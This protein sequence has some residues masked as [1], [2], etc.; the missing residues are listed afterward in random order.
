MLLA[1]CSFAW[2][3]APARPASRRTTPVS[4]K[5]PVEILVTGVNS[6]RISSKIVIQNNMDAVWRTLT[7]YD[8]LSTHVP[9]LIKSY[10]V[11]QKDGAIRVFQ[12]GAQNVVGFDFSA[13]LLMVM[14]EVRRDALRRPLP[15][16]YLS[17]TCVESFFF[18]VFSGE[19]RLVDAGAGDGG[20]KVVGNTPSSKR[21]TRTR[22]IGHD[23]PRASSSAEHSAHAIECRQGRRSVLGGAERQIMHSRSRGGHPLPST[24]CPATTA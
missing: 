12:E 22:Q 17:F 19:W 7:D 24:R 21:S 20:T 11:P 8:N 15:Q 6:R 16:P 13:S 2:A 4:L 1:S 9:N 23:P 5:A 14:K 3:G 10:R 18:Q